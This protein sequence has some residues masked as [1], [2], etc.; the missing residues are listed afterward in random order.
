MVTLASGAVPAR[1][2]TFDMDV[3]QLTKLSLEDLLQIEV[4]SV[5]KK[6][7][8]LSHTAAATFVLTQDDIRRSGA[9]SIPE[10]LRL[11]PGLHVARIDSNKWSV[12]SRGFSG[13][14][15]D[16][17][18]VMMDGRPLYSPL[19]AGVFWEAQDIPLEDIERIE[20]TRGP[21]GTLWGANATNGIVH[22]ITKSSKGTQGGLISAGGGTEEQAF[23]TVR[24]GD[25]L[26]QGF[27]Y[28]LYGKG[29]ARDSS[30]GPEGAADDWRKGQVGF[31]V[32][33][34][35]SVADQ[36]TLQGDYYRGEVEQQ[37]RLP[38]QTEP[39]SR[40][41]RE[42]VRLAGGNVGL[43]WTHHID[44]NSELALQLFYDRTSRDELSFGE[45][46]DSYM[47]DFQ[48]RFP[49]AWQQDIV[50]GL[51]YYLTTDDTR[52]DAPISF[53]PAS[54]DLYTA[55]AFVQ[56]EI[57]FLEDKLRLTLRAKYLNH[58]YAGDLFLPNV[59]I[60]WAPNDTQSLWASITRSARL[61]SRFEREGK[62]IID[63][64]ADGLVRLNG[65][66]AFQAETLWAYELGYRAQLFSRLSV[67]LAAF[68]NRYSGS[69]AEKE[70][71]EDRVLLTNDRTVTS[72]GGEIAAEWRPF[73]WW[74]LRPTFSYLQVRHTLRPGTESDDIG[75]DPAHQVSLRSLMNLSDT[76]EFDAAFRFV[77]RLPGTGVSAYQTLDLRLGWQP[78]KHVELSLV[79]QNLLNA[80][81]AEFMPELIQTSPVDIPRGFFGKISWRF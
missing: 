51:G 20:V 64:N 13:R 22:I 16:D 32:D 79:G 18:L 52:V 10:V 21:G 54:R 33:W 80:H 62:Q 38:T 65:N 27:H 50:W 3:K 19:F 44:T 36:L 63:A 41:R 30:I 42:D 57:G 4:T 49:L 74:R 12:T 72:Y 48:H 47:A 35:P 71:A 73:E 9:N 68:Y 60:L 70:L 40:S 2:E 43:R 8:S 14:F 1:D 78:F 37:T 6:S 75:T 55:S 56:D 45:T 31:R 81:H 66:P 29:F 15:A 39:F 24:Y 28:R 34:D 5:A 46:R 69:E 23:G 61:P 67:D 59:R 17:M 77:D 76:I 53:T 58:T 7:Q 26:G 25:R 11:A